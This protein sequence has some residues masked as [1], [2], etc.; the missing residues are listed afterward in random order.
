MELVKGRFPALKT[1]SFTFIIKNSLVMFF[2]L[3]VLTL[4]QRN[5]RNTIFTAFYL[6][7]EQ[8]E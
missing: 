7:M 4:T 8:F 5:Q 6:E 1:I 2:V 3:L